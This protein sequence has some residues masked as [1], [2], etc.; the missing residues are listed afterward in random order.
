MFVN[1]HFGLLKIGL[2]VNYM[3]YVSL[4]L[5]SLRFAAETMVAATYFFFM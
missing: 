5:K 3:S 4:F 2:Q 1:F